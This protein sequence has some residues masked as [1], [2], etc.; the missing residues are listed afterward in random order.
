MSM[1]KSLFTASASLTLVL[2]S[3]SLSGCQREEQADVAGLSRYTSENLSREVLLR[4]KATFA[5]PGAANKGS[6]KAKEIAKSVRSADGDKEKAAEAK[7]GVDVHSQPPEAVEKGVSVD[8]LAK[9]I[10]KKIKLVEGETPSSV[11]DKIN[12]AIDA[13]ADL[14]LADKDKLQDALNAA[15]RQ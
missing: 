12:K 13:D 9:N 11:L 6:T 10:A 2:S 1:L 15:L 4:Y 7:Y 14:P 8:D 3:L 5:K